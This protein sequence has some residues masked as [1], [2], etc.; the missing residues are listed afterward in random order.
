[1]HA[2]D[3]GGGL[4]AEL[5]LVFHVDRRDGQVAHAAIEPGAPAGPSVVLPF[6]RQTPLCNAASHDLPEG[7]LVERR[8]YHG[9]DVASTMPLHCT[10]SPCGDSA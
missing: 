1:M 4:R 7:V 10:I 8:L 6:A 3:D 9:N 5:Q 2:H